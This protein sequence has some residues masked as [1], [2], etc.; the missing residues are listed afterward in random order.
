MVNIYEE[1]KQSKLHVFPVTLFR[2]GL[3]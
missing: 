1:F 3:L 2:H